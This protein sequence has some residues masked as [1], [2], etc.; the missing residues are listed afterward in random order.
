MKERGLG[1]WG[2]RRNRCRKPLTRPG[3]GPEKPTTTF[4]ISQESNGAR[5]LSKWSLAALQYSMVKYLSCLER[6]HS[7]MLFPVDLSPLSRRLESPPVGRL[8]VARRRMDLGAVE[9][10]IAHLHAVDGCGCFESRQQTN[11]GLSGNKFQTEVL[12]LCQ[13]TPRPVE[14]RAL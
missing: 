2:A 5:S 13:T 7:L 1:D 14:T 4:D 6:V 10:W 9:K 11:A 8:T 3:Y 12:E